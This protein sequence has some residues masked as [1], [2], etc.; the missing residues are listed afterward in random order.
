MRFQSKNLLVILLL[1][2]IIF[3][4]QTPEFLTNAVH[5]IYGKIAL[6]TF[7]LFLFT[8]GPL[9]G[10]LAIGASYMVLVRSN[11]IISL[12]THKYIPS[13]EK[14]QEFFTHTGN[15]TFPKTLEEDAVENQV[16]LITDFPIIE[17]S[18]IPVVDYSHDALR[19]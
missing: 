12:N 3:D 15:N 17:S 10:I 14:K 19:V 13:E 11:K 4:I 2:F 5:N 16:P 18:Y 1:I 6:F 8:L 7:S 9:V